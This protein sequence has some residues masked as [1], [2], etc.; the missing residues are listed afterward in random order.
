MV[1]NNLSNLLWFNSISIQSNRYIEWTLSVFYFYAKPEIKMIVESLVLFLT[2]NYICIWCV[3]IVKKQS[4]CNRLKRADPQFQLTNC[5]CF[6]N[7]CLPG[8]LAGILPTFIDTAILS[9]WPEHPTPK[10]NVKE[11]LLKTIQN[12]VS[13]L[14]DLEFQ[15]I[16]VQ[17]FWA[18]SKRN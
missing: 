16:K 9:E 11:K 10:G 1:F 15:T 5:N 8:T 13:Y 4:F 2:L 7:T 18:K 3:Y 17:Y 6:A 14:L 12:P